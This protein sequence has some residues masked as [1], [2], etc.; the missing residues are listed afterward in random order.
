MYIKILKQCSLLI[1]V[2]ISV[3]GRAQVPRMYF[4]DTTTAGTSLAKDPIVVKFKGKY[5]MYYSR[6]ASNNSSN[7]MLGWDIGIA[8][9]TDLYNWVKIGE[10]K[11]AAAYEQK[12]L[13]APGAILKDGKIH[14]FYQTYGNGAKDAICHA[15]ST[16]GINFKRDTS[17]PIFHPAGKWTNGRAIDAEVYPF[18][19][20]YFL[21][22]ATRDSSGQIQKQGVASASIGA[23]FSKST[24]KQAVDSA[25]L[26]PVLPWEGNCIEGASII[27][28]NNKLYMFYAGNYNN[29][30]QQIGVAVSSDGKVWKRLSNQ[31][32]LPNGKPGSW[33]SSESGHPCIFEDSNAKTYLFYQG[34]NDNGKSWYLS[35]IEIGWTKNEPY[36]I[37]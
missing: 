3:A 17:N 7:G 28:R 16:D 11:P 6:K 20:K 15:V 4:S 13:C 34:N 21:Y 22:F 1:L 23:N 25:I 14:L 30:P 9:S 8:Q 19:N 2:L 10:I 27:K 31:P 36:I 35:N 12:G 24:W 37:K 5:L 18:Q 33:N 32:F 26:K 29:A